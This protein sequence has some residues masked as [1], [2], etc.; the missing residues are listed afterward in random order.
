[1]SY[2]SEDMV[3]AERTLV[4][5]DNS[6]KLKK[7]L[8][9]IIKVLVEDENQLRFVDNSQMIHLFKLFYSF[10]RNRSSYYDYRIGLKSSIWKGTTGTNVNVTKY[11][12]T[13]VTDLVAFKIHSF[14]NG[15]K[16]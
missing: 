8:M 5:L 10:I 2:R 15:L 4:E 1:M 6:G 12:P 16:A 14:D 3:D 9:D 11:C 13:L 7:I